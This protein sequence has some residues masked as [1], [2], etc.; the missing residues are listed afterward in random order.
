MLVSYFCRIE[1]FPYD[2]GVFPNAI[3]LM[4]GINTSVVYLNMNYA[5]G[6]LEEGG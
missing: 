1:A 5:S 4:K 2:T 6:N 3:Y